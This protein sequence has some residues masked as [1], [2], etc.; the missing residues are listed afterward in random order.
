[1]QC[2][3]LAQCIY[4]L[5][6]AGPLLFV[7][8]QCPEDDCPSQC[9]YRRNANGKTFIRN[10]YCFGESIYIYIYSDSYIYASI[11]TLNC[12]ARPE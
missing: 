6:L 2:R 8:S 5:Y 1:M 10:D 11:I 12:R 9:N 3:T 4:T 7:E